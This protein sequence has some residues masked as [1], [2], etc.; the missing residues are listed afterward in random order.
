MRTSLDPQLYGELV[1]EAKPHLIE[2]EEDY[3]ATLELGSY[4]C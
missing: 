1:R 2:T 3:E 4:C